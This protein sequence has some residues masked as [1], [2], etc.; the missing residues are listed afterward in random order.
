M[1]YILI[2]FAHRK[3]KKVDVPHIHGHSKL[4][5]AWTIGPALVMIWLLVISYDGLMKIDYPEADPEVFI[6]VT[7]SRFSWPMALWSPESWRPSPV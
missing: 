4:E 1:A 3:G 2:R 6:D 5:I 7:A